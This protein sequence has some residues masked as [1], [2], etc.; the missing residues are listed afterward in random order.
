MEDG[1]FV[2]K[3]SKATLNGKGK[4]ENQVMPAVF[5]TASPTLTKK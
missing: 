1:H 3:D 4:T 5:W 2:G